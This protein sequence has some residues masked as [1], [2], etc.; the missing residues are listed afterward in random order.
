MRRCARGGEKSGVMRLRI[1]RVALKRIVFAVASITGMAQALVLA[2]EAPSPEV[3][4]LRVIP[5]TVRLRGPDAGQQLAVEGIMM[6]DDPRDLTTGAHFVSSDP[7]VAAVD[8]RGWVTA[9][10]DGAARIF[11]RSG[12]L[13]ASVPISVREFSTA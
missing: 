9:R 11:V 1:G 3:T 5:A 8:D 6:A 2:A 4:G 13:T 12:R 7:R 10:G